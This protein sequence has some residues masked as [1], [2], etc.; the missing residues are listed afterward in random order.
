M[1]LTLAD[2]TIIDYA[3]FFKLCSNP[4][5]FFIAGNTA[6]CVSH[7]SSFRFE[8]LKAFFHNNERQSREI[9]N[10]GLFQLIEVTPAS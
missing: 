9:L 7:G 1:S 4:H 6:Q 3:F 10:G 5:G 2:N 8:D